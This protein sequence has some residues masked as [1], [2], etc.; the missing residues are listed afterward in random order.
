M[1]ELKVSSK[2]ETKPDCLVLKLEGNL[3]LFTFGDLKAAFERAE[4]EESAPRVA[5]DLSGVD[6]VAS[7]GWG[8][9]MARSKALKGQGGGMVIFGLNASNGHVYE[10]L[11]IE[12]I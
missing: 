4:A 7:S 6:Y 8:V 1:S 5:V 12:S 3:D 9:L 11:H 10:T 2:R